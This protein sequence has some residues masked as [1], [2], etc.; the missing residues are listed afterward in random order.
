MQIQ[1]ASPAHIADAL[2]LLNEYYE[3]IG[4]LQTDTP[5]AVQSFL[6]D[7][8]SGLWLAFIEGAP[9]GCVV[10]R[11]LSSIPFAGECKRLYVRPHLRRR[12]IAEALLDALEA[13]GKMIGLHQIYLD[14]KD[15]LEAALSIYSRRGYHP[16]SRYNDNP[17]ATIFLRKELQSIELS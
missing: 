3:S 15:D 12:G 14:S 7:K 11:P 10:L 2:L 17:Q 5:E 1:R 4:V 6:T 8:A 9:A 13:Y 16:C